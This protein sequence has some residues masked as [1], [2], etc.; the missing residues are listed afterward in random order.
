MEDLTAPFKKP[1]IMDIKMGVSSVGEDATPEKKANMR[2]KD[3]ATT[4]V[5]LGI[6]ICGL[7]VYFSNRKLKL[8]VISFKKEGICGKG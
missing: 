4:S 1:C 3:E 2:K 7:R 6:R 5:S 8:S